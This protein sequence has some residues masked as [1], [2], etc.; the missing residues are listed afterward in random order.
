M[1][2]TIYPY[3]FCLSN[4][5]LPCKKMLVSH[6]TI[7]YVCNI[8]DTAACTRKQERS[9]RSLLKSGMVGIW[10]VFKDENKSGYE[11]AGKNEYR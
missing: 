1:T 9:K 10:Q 5:S 11:E 8:S 6:K 2:K 4:N 3:I 7:F